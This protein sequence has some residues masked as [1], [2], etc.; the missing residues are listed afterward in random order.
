MT[1]RVK[2]HT[3]VFLWLIVRN[4]RPKSYRF[5]DRRIQVANL[6]IEV[7]HRPLGTVCRGP[8]GSFVASCLLEHDVNGSLWR[9]K[10][11][12]PRLLVANGPA[13]QF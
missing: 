11:D 10:Y 8:D 13:E 2:Q 1:G 3:D 5:A 7:H 12:S 9:S 4:F 6:E